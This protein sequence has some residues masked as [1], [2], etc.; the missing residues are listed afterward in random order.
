M[1]KLTR[2]LSLLMACAMLF[3]LAAC[4]SKPDASLEDSIKGGL[5]LL[6]TTKDSNREFALQI[7]QGDGYEYHIDGTITKDVMLASV[8]VLHNGLKSNYKN[9]IATKGNDLY[10]NLNS[11]MTAVEDET[12][13]M[14]TDSM[15][16]H[17]KHLLIPNGKSILTEWFNEMYI[18]NV[19]AWSNT[20][21]AQEA[22]KGDYDYNFEYNH[23]T[24]V[25]LATE[26]LNKFNASNNSSA[27][28]LDKH[29]TEITKDVNEDY[30]KALAYLNECIDI[31]TEEVLKEHETLGARYDR[32]W[33]QE[34]TALGNLLKQDGAYIKEGLS[35]TTK[36]GES[37]EHKITFFGKDDKVMGM[38][39]LTVTTVEQVDA[40][41][42]DTFQTISI[43]EFMPTFLS[44]VKN[45]KGVGYEVNDF[46]YDVTY[47]SN[48]LVAIETN[49]LYKATHTFTFNYDNL[50]EYNVAY[51]TYELYIHEALI[52]NAEKTALNLTAESSEA[53]RNGTGG[54]YISY[55]TGTIPEVYSCNSPVELL[56]ILKQLGVPSYD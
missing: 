52:R 18:T 25:N 50:T 40:V 21:Q 34:L 15:P 49:G 6:D 4:S 41:S 32:L 47:I 9:I 30:N 5:S 23:D 48:Q 20:R 36:D 14:F 33:A 3:S 54:G 11:T 35:Y 53:L 42:P 31:D 8:T 39:K 28:L 56:E 17:G 26:M 43:Q 13:F 27:T 16:F 2:I 37:Y 55:S 45:A 38:L 24:S 7:Q 10:L 19:H 44:N 1:K 46:P 29:L 51:E 22:I 12:S